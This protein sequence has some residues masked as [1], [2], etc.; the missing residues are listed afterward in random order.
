LKAQGL[1]GI[2]SE[3]LKAVKV[4]K[5]NGKNGTCP[6]RRTEKAFLSKIKIKE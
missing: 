4:E 6:I 2:M 1:I 5:L 3:N